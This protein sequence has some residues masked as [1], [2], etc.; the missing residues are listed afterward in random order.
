MAVFHLFS[1]RLNAR[2][3]RCPLALILRMTAQGPADLSGSGFGF[4]KLH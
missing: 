4:E 2:D 1:S 3:D